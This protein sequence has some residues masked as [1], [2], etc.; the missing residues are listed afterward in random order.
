[1]LLPIKKVVAEL[2]LN[3]CILLLKSLELLLLFL[4]EAF[5]SPTKS[6]CCQKPT[7]HNLL[8]T[9]EYHMVISGVIAHFSI[10]SS[11]RKGKDELL[12]ALVVARSECQLQ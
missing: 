11:G 7:L 8:S 5:F 3:I 4:K 9:F 6:S 2:V 10:N 12:C 1:M